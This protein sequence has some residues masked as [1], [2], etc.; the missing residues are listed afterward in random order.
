MVFGSHQRHVHALLGRK[1]P[2]PQT[3]RQHDGS[4]LD[5]PAIVKNDTIASAV[6][7]PKIVDTDVLDNTCA[8]GAGAPGQGHGDIGRADG[9]I[10]WQP[11]PADDVRDIAQ[12]ELLGDLVR[13]DLLGGHP[14]IASHGR[15]PAEL[16]PASFVR[17]EGDGARSSEAGGLPRLGLEALV[18]LE[19]VLGQPGQVFG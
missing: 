16:F 3:A 10:F 14:E 12:R 17:R 5:N 11:N 19:R 8:A 6:R 13:A 9:P 1:M 15:S 7:Q 2:G 4:G 18:Q